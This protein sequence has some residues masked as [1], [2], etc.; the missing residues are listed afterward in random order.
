MP[1]TFA[2]KPAAPSRH[3][4]GTALIEFVIVFPL[5]VLLLFGIIEFGINFDRKTAVTNAARE[6]ARA[7]V[8]GSYPGC[9]TGSDNTKLICLTKDRLGLEAA[10]TKVEIKLTS[11]SSVGDPLTVCV[12]YPTES[13]T[14]VFSSLLGGSTLKGKA[15]MRLEQD[16]SL[17]NGG[18][19][20][21][22]C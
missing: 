11:G 21:T 17:T 3:D 20:L 14:G 7:G 15:E 6:G 5:L 10:K 13:I 18:D 8:V 9:T 19:S 2:A 12:E 22:W 4:H 16:S 1:G